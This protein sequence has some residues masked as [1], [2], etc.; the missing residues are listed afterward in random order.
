MSDPNKLPKHKASAKRWHERPRLDGKPPARPR[1][2]HAVP[3]STVREA[4]PVPIN[5]RLGYRPAEFAA[6]TG[7]SYP[8]IWRRIKRGE[9][10]TVQIGGVKL[11]PRAFAV[12]CGLIKA[13][14]S[15]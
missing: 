12:Q 6:L 9:I 4:T 13:D 10:A 11:V 14:D 5:Q 15:I 2:R 7:L 1:G 3:D 8:T